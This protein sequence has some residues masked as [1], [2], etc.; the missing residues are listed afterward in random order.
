[1]VDLILKG[2]ATLNGSAKAP[3]SKAYTHRAIIAASLSNGSSMVHNALICDDTLATMNACRMLGAEIDKLSDNVIRVSGMP[4]PETPND[5]INCGESGSTMRFITPI[6]ALADGISVLTGGE[7]LRRRPMGP[8]IEALNHLGVK[9][10]SAR[11]DGY[12]P[13]IVFG[14]GIRGGKAFIR[15]DVSSQFI[16][17][18]LFAAPLAEGDVDIILLTPLESKPY[19]DITLDVICRH[20][21]KV[22]VSENMFHVPCMQEYG[23]HDHFI[24]GDYSS[25]AFLLAAASIT[26]SHVRIE[27]LP[28]NTLQGDSAIIKVL[29]E[30][31]AHIKVGDNFIEVDGAERPLKPINVDMR[32]NPDL[33][34]VCAILACVSNGKSVIRGVR[35]LKFKESDRVEALL[36]ELGKMGA[37]ITFSD[38]SLIIY[39]GGNLHGAEIDPHGDHRIAMACAVLA[40]NARGETVIHNAECINKSYPDFVRDMRLLGAE[41]LER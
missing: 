39:G 6:C 19:V 32:D 27:N 1:M 25:A 21:I 31:G 29:S 28:A 11:M 17:G 40:L 20:G 4:K 8:L 24:E 26:N 12:P 36:S 7:S 2:G 18:L 9:C 3:P 41:I 13:I 5:V 30:A 33:V 35:R 22:S 38:D 14:G 10:Y 23:P 37:N 15:G 34:P 16:S